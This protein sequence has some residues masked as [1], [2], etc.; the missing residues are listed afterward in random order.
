NKGIAKRLLNYFSFVFTSLYIGLT[1]T[2]KYDYILCE[3]PPLFLGITAYILKKTKGS[4]LIFNVSD[5]WPESAEKLGLVTNTTF[6]K[7]ATVLEEFLYR[8][9][10]LITGQT[11]G[12]CKNIS[13]RFPNKKVYWLPNGVDM[14]YYNADSITT[15]WRAENNFMTDDF[16]LLYAGIIGHAQG[17]EVVLNAAALTRNTTQIKYVLLGSGPEKEKLQALQTQL[18]L[19][20]VY[21]YDAVTK[22]KM[23]AIVKAIDVAVIPL[24]K[25]DL[26][27]GAIPSKIFENLA[28]KKAIVLGVEGEAKELFID[29]GNCGLAFEPENAHDLAQKAT[30]LFNQ[31]AAVAQLGIN[32]YNYVQTKFTRDHIANNF[33]EV[34]QQA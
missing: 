26:F 15:Q 17:L 23:P 27:K 9:S 24:K 29:E 8:N 20:N 4:K 34:L 3:S 7:M 30:Q 21:F 33:W 18:A 5:L 6:L 31:R 11:Q 32:G 10:E 14:N 2:G 25:L 22:D 28:M 19:T 13:A 16:I 1:K 12:I